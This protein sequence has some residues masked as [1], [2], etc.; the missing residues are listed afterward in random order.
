[1]CP[2]DRQSVSERSGQCV[3]GGEGQLVVCRASEQRLGVAD[4]VEFL[5]V[6]PFR[7]VQRRRLID[8]AQLQTFEIGH[9]ARRG[10]KASVKEFDHLDS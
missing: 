5:A 2:Y 9:F 4:G 10:L 8:S 6:F 3:D 7:Q 1:M